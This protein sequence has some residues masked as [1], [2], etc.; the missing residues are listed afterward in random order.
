MA[1]MERT[2]RVG[3]DILDIDGTVLTQ[4]PG[5]VMGSRIEDFDE[6]D[7]RYARGRR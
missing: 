6:R 1:D 5:A 3:R 7:R 4:L 2:G